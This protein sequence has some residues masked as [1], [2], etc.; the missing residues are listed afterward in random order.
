MRHRLLLL[1]AVALGIVVGSGTAAGA[2]CIGPT[3]EF[4]PSAAP[5]GGEVTVVG[6]GF[7]DNCYDTG[8]PPAGEGVLGVPQRDVQVL[9]VQGAGE[10]LVAK[11][12]ADAAYAF[13]VTI[14]VPPALV[15][16]EAQFVA[17]LADGREAF[18]PQSEGLTIT[19]G[20]PVEGA[21]EDV[22]IFGDDAAGG[23]PTTDATAT[24]DDGDEGPPWELIGLSLFVLAVAATV[25]YPLRRM[26]GAAP[27]A[28][29]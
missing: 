25:I 22:V 11:G 2:D 10:T 13:E 26:R 29:E 15:P 18:V 7:G 4:E 12:D 28:D 27:A 17:R 23:P 20:P 3:L 5:R 16:G 1:L 21:V 9:L 14:V 19:D 24:V 8:P 6:S